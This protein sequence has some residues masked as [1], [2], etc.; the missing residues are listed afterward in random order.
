M[1]SLYCLFA[2]GVIK[3]KSDLRGNFGLLISNRNSKTQYQL[4]MLGKM[5]FFFSSIMI[6]SP[7][8]PQELVTMT[9]LNDLSSIF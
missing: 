7:K 6:L 1:E 3:L 2:F 4:E 9:T 8:L 5:S